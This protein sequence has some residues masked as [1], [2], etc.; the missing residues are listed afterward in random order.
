MT[1]LS[2]STTEIENERVPA[3]GLFQ[4]SGGD[5]SAPSQV[6]RFGIVPPAR[7]AG[8]AIVNFGAAATEP[9]PTRADAETATQIH[10][11]IAAV[12]TG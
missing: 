9:T 11:L 6:N 8:L 1:P 5:T 2:R 10:S 3:G 12:L 4:R 7:K